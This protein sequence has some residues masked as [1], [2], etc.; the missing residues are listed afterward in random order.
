MVLNNGD[1]RE[2]DRGDD[3]RH[4][5]GTASEWSGNSE[6]GA[7]QDAPLIPRP[8]IKQSEELAR[9]VL[10]EASIHALRRR[11]LCDDYQLLHM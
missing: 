5:D 4:S 10:G 8:R 1:D 2:H 9:L 7:V 3:H 11:N 6:I